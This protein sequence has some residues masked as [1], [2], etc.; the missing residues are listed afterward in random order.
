V[1]CASLHKKIQCT[2]KDWTIE[3]HQLESNYLTVRAAYKDLNKMN[4]MRAAFRPKES[5][6]KVELNLSI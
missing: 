3:M 5:N 4:Y 2:L 1:H 6:D